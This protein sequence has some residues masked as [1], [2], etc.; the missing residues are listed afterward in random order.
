MIASQAARAPRNCTTL[1]GV[2]LNGCRNAMTHEHDAQDPL[3]QALMLREHNIEE[4][5]LKNLRW[6]IFS[7]DATDTSNLYRF[8]TDTRRCLNRLSIYDSNDGNGNKGSLIISFFT[9]LF[10]KIILENRGFTSY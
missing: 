9:D 1:K 6:D 10:S 3:F 4:I 2:H 7:R 5:F 8:L